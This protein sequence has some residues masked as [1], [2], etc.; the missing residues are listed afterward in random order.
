MADSMVSKFGSDEWLPKINDLCFDYLKN[1][2]KRPGGQFLRFKDELLGTKEKP[3]KIVNEYHNSVD[4]FKRDVYDANAEISYIDHH[5]IA[6]LYIRS[7]LVHQPFVMDIP[8]QT[9]NPGL[10]LYT[11]LPNE[12]FSIP[13]LAAI[14][15][16]ANEKNEK[17]DCT[18]KMP[19]VYMNN[20]VKL[21]HYN[22]NN[23]DKYE[24]TAFS[25]IFYLIEQ[26]YFKEK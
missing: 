24:P 25:N 1:L 7:F 18:I 26:I 14:Y 19:I 20:F 17:R 3:G 11:K 21:L 15:K 22:K 12:Y 10:C 4:K 6:A 9:K 5:K 2:Q 8:T 23:I 13:F 16:T